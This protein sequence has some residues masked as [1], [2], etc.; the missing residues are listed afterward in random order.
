MAKK[1]DTGPRIAQLIAFLNISGRE[2]SRQIDI[3]HSLLKSIVAGSAFGVD[4]LSKIMDVYPQVNLDW[5]LTGNGDM[6][7]LVDPELN[8]DLNPGLN[9]DAKYNIEKDTSQAGEP[10]LSYKRVH[11][12]EAEN[13][14]LKAANAALIEAFKAIGEGKAHGGG[15]MAHKEQKSA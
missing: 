3:P 14:R 13:E 8:P 15:N 11:E 5:I 9:P 2:F 4:K 12:L 1:L 7:K 10:E 6:I